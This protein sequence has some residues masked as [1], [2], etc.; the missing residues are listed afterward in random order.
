MIVPKTR[1]LERPAPTIPASPS[2]SVRSPPP[3]APYPA[4]Y[5]LVTRLQPGNAVASGARAHGSEGRTRRRPPATV[6][7]PELGHKGRILSESAVLP[8][9]QPIQNIPRSDPVPASPSPPACPAPPSR[10]YPC[11]IPVPYPLS[12]V[13]TT[14]FARK[15]IT[16]AANTK[17]FAD[18]TREQHCMNCFASF[19]PHF[20][21]RRCRSFTTTG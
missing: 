1:H 12:S 18:Q 4:R 5:P 9:D 8:E 20:I 7:K 16:W 19:H 15:K 6:P 13:R 14:L 21:A 10:I 2:P 17:F 3:V 11:Q